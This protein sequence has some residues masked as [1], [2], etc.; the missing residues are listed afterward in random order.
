MRL[1]IDSQRRIPAHRLVFGWEAPCD[2]SRD[3]SWGPDETDNPHTLHLSDAG[4][5]EFSRHYRRTDENGYRGDFHV[6]AAGR[7]TSSTKARGE[8]RVALQVTKGAQIVDNCSTGEVEWSATTRQVYS[9][10]FEPRVR[11]GTV[12]FG[13]HEYIRS[14]R[15]STWGGDAAHGRGIYPVNDCEPSCAE[16][17]YTDYPVRVRLSDVKRCRGRY[18]YLHLAWTFYADRPPHAHRTGHTSYEYLC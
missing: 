2:S 11:P 15:W 17:H 10:G 3:A 18:E 7:F 9:G 14:I 5:F 13:A 6:K 8:L 4:H 1:K 16:G 12:Y